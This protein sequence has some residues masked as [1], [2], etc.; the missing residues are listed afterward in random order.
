MGWLFA[1]AF[2]DGQLGRAALVR[3]HSLTY[4][5]RVTARLYA[6]AGAILIVL[7]LLT[8][9]V[10]VDDSEAMTDADSSA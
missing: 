3:W 4:V 9:A 1:D 10:L 2:V 6:V 8:A 5:W 7:T